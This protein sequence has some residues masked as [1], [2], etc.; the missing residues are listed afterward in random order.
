MG[1]LDRIRSFL[2]A[3]RRRFLLRDLL[4]WGALAGCGLLVLLLLLAVTAATLGPAGFWLP[5]TLFLAV[6]CVAAIIFAGVWRPSRLLRADPGARRLVARLRP[7]LGAL[8]GDIV[9]AVELGDGE[10]GPALPGSTLPQVVPLAFS[11][12]ES[13]ISPSL[14]RAFQGRVAESLRPL[15][16]IQLIPMRP[17]WQGG[18]ALLGAGTVLL[19]SATLSPE[20]IGRGLSTLFHRPSRFEG[21]AVSAKPIVGDVRIT[22]EYPPYTGLPP[23]TIEGSTGDVVAVKGTRVKIETAPLRTSRQ[24]M[25]LLGEA[26]ENGDLPARL[27]KGNIS[28]QLTLN[29]SGAY[30]F[31][32]QPLIGRAVREQR[33]HRLEVEVD[34]PPRVEIHGPADRLELPT[35]RPIEIGFAAD[36]D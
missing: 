8:G 33:S 5:L 6:I 29:Q 25:L 2:E 30:R 21:A 32:L 26:G 1:E 36:D 16:P 3:T 18:L 22:Y 4:R 17:A 13:A 34:R 31:W 15:S 27:A 7:P 35:P 11:R 9:S 12:R 28:V 24:A 10:C 23:R 19:G 20:M 14:V